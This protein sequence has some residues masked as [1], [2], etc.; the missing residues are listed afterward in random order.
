[1]PLVYVCDPFLAA[2]LS[3]TDG[4]AKLLETGL[5]YLAVLLSGEA[6]Y[7]FAVVIR[8]AACLLVVA[9]TRFSLPLCSIL[10]P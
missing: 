8:F 9:D 4:V 10:S 2:G 3:I 7:R 6:L 1:M 5:L